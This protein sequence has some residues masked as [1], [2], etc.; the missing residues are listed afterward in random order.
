VK[1][2]TVSINETIASGMRAV[3][4]IIVNHERLREDEDK[5]RELIIQTSLTSDMATE[6]LGLC[7][8]GSTHLHQHSDDLPKWVKCFKELI[9]YRCVCV[10]IVAVCLVLS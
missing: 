9:H 2:L 7:D 3:S 6:V 10:C 8:M 5:R 1:K 4:T